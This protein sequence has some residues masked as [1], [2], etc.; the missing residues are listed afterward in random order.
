MVKGPEDER[1]VGNIDQCEDQS[2]NEV[3]NYSIVTADTDQRED[4][5]VDKLTTMN[6]EMLSK[7]QMADISLQSIREKSFAILEEAEEEPMSLFW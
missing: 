5:E 6:V 1:T 4:I 3:V 2:K 7:L